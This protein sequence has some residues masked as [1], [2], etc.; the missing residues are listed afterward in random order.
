MGR[1]MATPN[2]FT[3]PSTPHVRRHG[4]AGY[5]DYES[6]RD[7]LRD[8]FSFRCV[9]CLNREQWGVVSGNWDIDHF[10]AQ[11]LFP[12]GKLLYEN[13]LNVCRRCNLIKSR[14]LV[15]DP[16]QIAFGRC[17]TVQDDG[18]IKAVSEHGEILIELLRLD[19][20]DL[21]H[22]RRLVINTIRSL[23]LHDRDTFIQWMG[24]PQNL[25]DLS[26]LKPPSNTKPE[27]VSDSFYAR[28]CRG[29]LPE[30]Y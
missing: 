21:T 27:G 5:K 18:T 22:F 29:G 12:S 14:R 8:D 4:P 11:A 13:L 15:L 26:K 6:Y 16:C 3:Y 7:W 17:L 2:P 10:V 25:P 19:R 28:R 1:V 9:F 23:A 20:E 24:Y 30:T